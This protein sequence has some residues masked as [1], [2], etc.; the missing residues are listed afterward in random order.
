[1][2]ITATVTNAKYNNAGNT[3]LDCQATINGKGPYP[4]TAVP[5]SQDATVEAVWAAAIQVG[6]AAYTPPVPPVLT[7]AQQAAV[8]MGEGLQVT[9]ISMPAIN[10][11]YGCDQVSLINITGVFAYV[12]AKNQF[13]GA[14]NSFTWY[15][16]AGIGHTFT[17]V[18][19]F[20]VFAET[21]CTFVAGVQEWV[22]GGGQGAA[23]SNV[24]TIA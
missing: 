4:Y 17:D 14:A 16:T 6:V 22:L 5:N 8:L 10:G 9:S 11:I 7:P 23:P 18:A 21:L 12:E 24:V 15:D 2:T 13:P 19:E 3:S 20:L 1:M